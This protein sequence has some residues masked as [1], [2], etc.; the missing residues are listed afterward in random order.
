[1]RGF[2][3]QESTASRRGLK[4]RRDRLARYSRSLNVP[5]NL[6]FPRSGAIEG[7]SNIP[8]LR[9]TRKGSGKGRFEQKKK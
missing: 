7:V 4:V 1:M 9:V 8:S 2:S 5:I 3:Q 6:Q